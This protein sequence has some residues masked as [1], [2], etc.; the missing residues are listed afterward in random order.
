[1][2]ECVRESKNYV[3]AMMQNKSS[4]NASFVWLF[5][6]VDNNLQY[7]QTR[8]CIRCVTRRTL[9]V[10]TPFIRDSERPLVL[11]FIIVVVVVA[12]SVPADVAARHSTAARMGH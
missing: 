4:S 12:V 1:M 8:K 3:C 9:L 11:L 6:S 2:H 7:K 5:Y 10:G